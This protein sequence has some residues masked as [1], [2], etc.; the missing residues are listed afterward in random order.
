[1]STQNV[2]FQIVFAQ[3]D[4]IDCNT[5]S[6]INQ[7]TSAINISNLDTN[8]TILL[9]ENQSVTLSASTGFVLPPLRVQ[10]FSGFVASVIT[11]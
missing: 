8:A 4:F 5:F 10:G 6:I 9:N 1:M 11:T 3:T 2:N 7:G